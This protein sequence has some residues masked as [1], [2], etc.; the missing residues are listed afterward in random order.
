MADPAAPPRAAGLDRV[1][2]GGRTDASSVWY[3][4]MSR[5]RMDGVQALHT[6]LFP[7]VYTQAFYDTLLTDGMVTYLACCEEGLLGVSTARVLEADAWPC[8]QPAVRGYIN[9]FG[10]DNRHRRRKIGSKLLSNTLQELARR[11]CNTVE[12][13]VL[14]DNLPA[15]GFYRKHGFR[16]SQLIENYYYI[17]HQYCDAYRMVCQLRAVASPLASL[18]RLPYTYACRLFGVPVPE[19]DDKE[20]AAALEY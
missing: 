2:I 1:V 15:L 7:V 3:E 11:G 18:L 13:H 16:M 5:G 17:D 14:T 20:P 19:P 9:T 4:P 6:E 10:V 8:F 12:L